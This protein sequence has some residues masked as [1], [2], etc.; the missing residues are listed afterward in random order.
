MPH[1]D[2]ET[3]LALDVESERGEVRQL[4][5]D[6]MAEAVTLPRTALEDVAAA[7]RAALARG[8]V[9]GGRNDLERATVS[10]TATYEDTAAA[11][12]DMAADLRERGRPEAA[13]KIEAHV[14]H[15]DEQRLAVLAGLDDDA[16]LD[17]GVALARSRRT[18]SHRTD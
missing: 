3:T 2:D 14:Q 8:L 17:A 1:W 16:A 7:A 11:L 5:T 15:F 13:A 4:L 9:A 6:A 18:G 12:L 10:R